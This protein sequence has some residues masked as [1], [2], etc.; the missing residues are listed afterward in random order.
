MLASA[1][2][3]SSRPVIRLRALVAEQ[4]APARQRL[5]RLLAT[6]PGV[7]IV[8]IASDG[9]EAVAL[10][11]AHRPDLAIIDVQLPHLDGLLAVREMLRVNPTMSCIVTS[12]EGDRQRLRQAMA[13]GARDFLLKPFT[14]NELTDAVYRVAN[15]NINVHRQTRPTRRAEA[16]AAAASKRRLLAQAATFAQSRRA[17]DTACGVFETLAADPHC[18]RRWLKTLAMVYV[19]RQEWHKLSR[20]A[21]RL[22]AA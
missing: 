22:S 8:A 1:T 6:I 5:Q 10:M 4:S 2:S 16:G 18:D 13:A 3:T 15:I 12:A 20:L 7:Q 19:V 9:A 14:E 17:D 21:Q 11:T